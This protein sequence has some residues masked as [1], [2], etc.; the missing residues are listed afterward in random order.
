MEVLRNPPTQWRALPRAG[1]PSEELEQA[2]RKPITGPVK[3]A[4]LFVAFRCHY[5]LYY[6]LAT[7]QLPPTSLWP[8]AGTVTTV[9]S[10]TAS[11]LLVRCGIMIEM[12]MQ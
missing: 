3:S 4:S 7:G 10:G 5:A 2:R 1:S 12:L 9:M 6:V 11:L 8:K